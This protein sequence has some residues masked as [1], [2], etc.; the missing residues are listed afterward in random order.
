MIASYYTMTARGI[1][2]CQFPHSGP[3]DLPFDLFG[4]NE[5]SD[6]VLKSTHIDGLTLRGRQRLTIIDIWYSCMTN[7]G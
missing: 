2:S 3:F 1:Y 5:A 7:Q 4:L 6:N